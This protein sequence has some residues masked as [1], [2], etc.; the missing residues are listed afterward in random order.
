[1]LRRNFRRTNLYSRGKITLNCLKTCK[2]AKV[3]RQEESSRSLF[4]YSFLFD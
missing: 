1:M 2:K 4:G 3:K